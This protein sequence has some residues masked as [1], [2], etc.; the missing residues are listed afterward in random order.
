M[1]IAIVWRSLKSSLQLT[2]RSS[3]YSFSHIY[4]YICV[5]VCKCN[6][7]QLFFSYPLCSVSIDVCPSSE[8][9]L[10]NFV[11]NC[12]CITA[13]TY[14]QLCKSYLVFYFL[15]YLFCFNIQICILKKSILGNKNFHS[16]RNGTSTSTSKYVGH[17]KVDYL[18]KKLFISGLSTERHSHSP[19]QIKARQ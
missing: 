16:N 5:H 17:T 10:Y 12:V 9:V 8:C 7:K 13:Y 3:N 2:H 14:I 15:F 18:K 1:P 11:W 4:V 19:L 6:L